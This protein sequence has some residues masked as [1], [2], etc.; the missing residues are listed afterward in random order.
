MDVLIKA[1]GSDLSRELKLTIFACIS[2]CFMAVGRDHATP[3]LKP[4]L[5]IVNL[6]LQGA[7]ALSS[8]PEEFEYAENLKEAAVDL[9]QCVNYTMSLNTSAID[10]TYTVP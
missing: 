2:D 1:M 6:G 7:I 5:D 9:Y 10:P 8:K 3:Y 4:V